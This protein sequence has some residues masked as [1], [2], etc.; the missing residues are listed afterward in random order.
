MRLAMPLLVLLLAAAPAFANPKAMRAGDELSVT[1]HSI[2]IGGE[3]LA[4]TA[5]VGYLILPDEKGKP[6]ANLFHIA[7]LRDGLEDPATRPVTF[8]FNGGP[9]SSSVWLHMGALG[10]RRVAMRED[11]HA[12]PP[13]YRSIP[14]EHTWLPFTDLVFIDPVTTGYSRAAE[15]VN[16][17]Q[18]HGLH[19]DARSVGDFI[20]LWLDREHRRGSPIFLVGESYG[21]TRAAQLAAHLHRGLGIDV[22]GVVLVSGVLNFQTIGFARGNDLP[23]WLYLPTYAATAW[24]HEKVDPERK[25]GLEETMRRAEAYARGDYLLAL[26]K[27]DDL[28]D[29]E[30]FDAVARFA[31]LTGLSRDFVEACDLRVAPHEFQKELLR[32]EGASTGRYDTRLLGVDRRRAGSGPDHDPSMETIRGPFTA[33]LL[34]DFRRRLGYENDLVYEVLTGKVHPWPMGH[35]YDRHRYADVSGTLGDTMR[36]LPHLRVL[37]ACGVYDLATPYYGMHYTLAHMGLGVEREHRVTFATYEAGHMMYIHLPSLR[38]LTADA[39]AFYRGGPEEGAEP[40][41]PGR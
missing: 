13:P 28:T 20:R 5:K 29:G 32:H 40:G 1:S 31:E 4:Y 26:A 18:F 23:H 27:G 19:E 6:R 7:Y 37:A 2:E 17:K 12:L 38:K 24:Y 15:G 3:K 11:G 14:N 39:A 30:R 36:Q 33:A 10:P 22:S 35:A 8:A 25:V 34:D 41:E 21:S 16:P 9:G